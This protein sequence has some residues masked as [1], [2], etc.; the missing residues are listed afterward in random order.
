[1]ILFYRI[2]HNV[3]WFKVFSENSVHWIF[4]GLNI[5][6]YLLCHVIIRLGHSKTLLCK[7]KRILCLR[8]I[9]FNRHRT[10]LL[11]HGVLYRLFRYSN[12]VDS[13]FCTL[14]YYYDISLMHIKKSMIIV[15]QNPI[16]NGWLEI[17]FMVITRVGI[18]W[19]LHISYRMLD[20]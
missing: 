19:H 17:N 6:W 14:K 8:Y 5:I 4:S 13:F 12:V 7:N 16:L 11:S 20:K 9:C 1:L 15:I 18:L 3:Y 2:F 10:E